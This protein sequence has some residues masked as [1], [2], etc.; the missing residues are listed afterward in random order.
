MLADVDR[1]SDVP[2]SIT[3]VIPALNEELRIPEAVRS[4]LEG[5]RVS[6]IVVDG[7][8]QDQTCRA[9]E[10]AGAQVLQGPR[11]R[12]LQMNAGAAAADGDILLF[13]HADSQLPAGWDMAVRSSLASEEVAAGAFRFKVR[14][15]LPGIR[16][17]E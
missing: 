13:L 8:S 14:E 17:V 4:A 12:A 2:R 1:P 3:V 5:F 11:G 10:V 7:G 16:L 15:R 6:V 9:A